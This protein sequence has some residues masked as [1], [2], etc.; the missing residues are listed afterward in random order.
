MTGFSAR[1]LPVVILLLAAPSQAQTQAQRFPAFDPERIFML[2]DAD[3]DGRLSLDEYREFLRSAPRMKNAA[4]TIEPMFRRLDAD[5]DGFLSLAEY[6]KSFPQRPGGAPAKPDARHGKPPGAAPP[7][8]AITPEQEQFFETKIRPVLV[9]HCGK[10][11]ASNAEKLR[12][13]LQLDTRDGLRLG[14]DSG[15]AIV[16]GQPD[17]SRLLRAIRYRDDELRMPPKAKL[18]DA[19]VADF[20]AWITMGAPDPRTGPAAS[21]ARPS[22]DV[23]KGREFWSFRPPKASAPPSVRRTDWPRGDIDRFLLAALEARGLAPVAD[24]DRARLLR[25]VTLD[26]IGLPPT[27]E[28]LDAFLANDS[29]DALSKLVDRLL[30]SPRFGERW[31][32]HWLDVARYAESSGKTNFTYPQAW[33]YR[34]WTIAAFNADKSYDQFVREQVAGD[35]L[36]AA[37]D[38]QRADQIIA[39]GFLALGSKA[40]DGE[41]RG[42][43]VLD[44]IDEQIEATTRAFLGLTVACARCHDHK[45]DP[46]PQR[47]YYALSGIFRSTQTCSGTLAGVFPNFNASPLIELPAGAKLPSA[48]PALTSEQRAAMEERLASLVR[49]RDAIP[50]GEANRDRLRRA[51]SMLATLRYRLLLD[52]PGGPP[53][54]FAMGVRERDETIDSPLYVRGE[55]DQPGAVVP[56]ALF[57]VICEEG[58]API[59]EGSGRR[60]L[61]DRLAS[62]SNP[63]T[64]RVMVNRVWLHLFGRGLVPTPDNFGAA[65]ARPSHPELLDTLA[66]DFMN[67]GWS[68]KRLI[69][70]IVLSRA[71][72]LDSAHDPRN[73]EADPDNALV[74]RMSKRRLDAEAVRDALLFVGGRLAIE[75]PI[76]SAVARVGEG[77]AFFVRVEGLDASDPHRSVY[78]PVVRDQVLESLALFDFADPSLVTG[79]RATTTGPAQALYFL[80]GPLVI[81]QAEALADRVRASE[82]DQSHRVD[83]AYRIALSRG[84][85]AAERDRALTFLREFAARVEGTD[86]ARGAWAAFC[87]TLLAGAEFRYRD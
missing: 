47:D 15:P 68:T 61:A 19:V 40:H 14:G 62:L 69:R 1:M 29:P 60:E 43:F 83:W 33:R 30:A 28:E 56:R 6:R 84:P 52:R 39:T 5:R 53:R 58:T 71:Y 72:G 86:P 18:P 20:E 37:D 51:N 80:N 67:D 81:R 77:L 16:P 27:P 66:V 11:H 70:R 7:D 3:L 87:Q 12:G 31:G 10:C 17:E 25:R 2:G 23:A 59:A 9:T 4:A 21:A 50:P 26:L 22:I 74:W 44:V 46:I 38:R 36:P 63:L 75:P 78:L 65:G 13:G 34:D 35:L 76:G 85:T 8:V 55:L 41:N 82:A 45:M 49:E 54:A 48:V 24:A 73:F 57:R 64:A 42:Q 79:E 32:R